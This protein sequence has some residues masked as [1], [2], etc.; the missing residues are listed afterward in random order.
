MVVNIYRHF[1]IFR[2][3]R[4]FCSIYFVLI[5][6]DGT[7]KSSFCFGL[8]HQRDESLDDSS[9]LRCYGPKLVVAVK[10]EFSAVRVAA[11]V[12]RLIPIDG[13]SKDAQEEHPHGAEEQGVELAYHC[14]RP[15]LEHTH[16]H[17]KRKNIFC[18]PDK[19]S[20]FGGPE[21]WRLKQN[22]LRGNISHLMFIRKGSKW[23]SHKAESLLAHKYVAQLHKDWSKMKID[24]IFFFNVFSF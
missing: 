5:K 18:Q 9:Y 23:H 15:E 19:S 20:C 1:G 17:I 6:A 14:R 2:I 11:E 16:T 22:P 4:M 7:S 8:W 24:F 10:V 13:E 12:Q 3:V 21:L